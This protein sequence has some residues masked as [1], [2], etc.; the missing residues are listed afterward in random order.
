MRDPRPPQRISRSSAPVSDVLDAQ[1]W[2]SIRPLLRAA[3]ADEEQSI[4]LLR[5][6]ATLLVE[7][8]RTVSNL[9]SS[10]DEPRLVDRHLR[11]SLEP[12]RWIVESDLSRWIDFGSGAGFPAI[13]LAIAGA[14]RQWTLVEAR[15]PKT[16]FVRKILQTLSLRGINVIHSRL[17]EVVRAGDHHA[18]FDGF[19]SR[20]TMPLAPTLLMAAQLVRDR[21]EAFLWK[22]SRREEELKADSSRSEE[23]RVGKECRSRWSP[24]H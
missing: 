17:E 19:T 10:N 24:Y 9:M 23:R 1:D 15:R 4:A 21:G 20:A 12:A 6:Y 16:L 7:W 22:G 5:R 18:A 13:P 2:D 11:E 8:N 3:G 14:G